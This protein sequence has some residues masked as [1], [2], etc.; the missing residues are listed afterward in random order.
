MKRLFIILITLTNLI[1]LNSQD[2]LMQG[3]Y[4]DY[5]KTANGANFSDSLLNKVNEL[6]D[7]GITQ[8]WLPPLS[9]ASFGSNSN[10]YD[11]QDLYDLGEYGL[12]PTGFGTRSQVDALITAL[13]N[14]GIEPIAD[15]VYNHRDGGKPE[16]NPAVEGW[17]ENMN[18]TKISNGDQPF[19][20]D[21]VRMILP[22]GGST[23]NGAG[24]YYMK[25][26]SASKHPNFYDKPYKFY[27]QTNTQGFKGL[28]AIDENEGAP[29]GNGG[30]DCNG[31][32]SI[33][34]ELGVDVLA[35]IDNV[36]SCGGS[37]GVDEI[38]LV[39]N[40]EE[41][42]PAGD[43]IFIFIT[44][45]AGY[46]DHHIYGIWSTS[47]SQDV[48]AEMRYQTYTDFSS[49]PSG[50]GSMN[51]LNF[52]PNGNP[53]N[54]GGDWDYM[55][56]FY[57]YDQ[58]VADTRQKLIDWSQW[59]WDDVGIRGLRMDA[60][61]HFDYRFVSDLMDSLHNVGQDHHMIVGE[62][63]DT[64]PFVLKGWTDNVIAN[65]EPATNSAMKIKVFD[66]ALRSSLEA[67]CDAFGY[68]VRNVFTS[69]IVE[70]A[71]GNTYHV[72][73][74]VNNHDYRDAFQPIDNDPLLAYAYI[75]TN[76]EVG[77]P[78][79]FYPDYFGITLP[80]GPDDKLATDINRILGIYNQFMV[81]GS[82]DFLNNI[83]TP[84]SISYN[85]SGRETT[86]L[87]Y[88]S[89]DGGLTGDKDAIVA[90]NFAGDTL[91]VEFPVSGNSS[92]SIGTVFHDLTGKALTPT[93][94]LEGNNRLKVVIP[95]RSF[96][97]FVDAEVN[98]ICSAGSVIYVDKNAS[99]LNNGKDWEHAFKNLNSAIQYAKRCP[100]IQEIWVKEGVYNPNV[101]NNR[102]QTFH[103]DR[104]IKIIGG[105]P[106][107]IP[108]PEMVD[109]DPDQF[110]TIFSANIG[111]ENM[112]EDNTYHVVVNESTEMVFISGVT[113]EGGYANGVSSTDQSGSGIYNT[114]LL[115]LEDVI[116]R[117][118][119]NINNQGQ[120]TI[121]GN[122]EVK[123]IHCVIEDNVVLKTKEIKK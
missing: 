88:H 49:L 25:I 13:N 123:M 34:A 89:Y 17:I 81:G 59:L 7:A 87:I 109:R 55:Y 57:D 14:A 105:F 78:S 91:T 118:C 71:G 64:N 72:V 16:L 36:G 85:P 83:G 39:V 41:F 75:L 67:A 113:L 60:V 74:F 56:F 38:A 50:Q 10:G 9:R 104:G 20:S 119:S 27:A 62:F 19:P 86:T 24:T 58:G 112:I 23:G 6:K 101:L 82:I 37:C 48:Q 42:N 45:S 77:Q 84:A 28:A 21:R 29:G 120:L 94:E 97:I 8:L 4:W 70:G 73:T 65:A 76:R 106:A 15:V 2:V 47:K 3:W 44:N 46:T 63:F 66:F 53:T 93:A 30:G 40:E 110:I 11:P 61:K 96:G 95:P 68:D 22:I 54:L 116:I 33:P 107:H 35:T 100:E 52:K 51:Y 26:A 18:C 103:L 121:D 117:D 32:G 115:T 69:G 114:G 122:G 111:D 108:N 80:H 5:P 102:S 12:G 90:I 79:V 99:G 92:K 1:S 98:E 31:Q 43:T